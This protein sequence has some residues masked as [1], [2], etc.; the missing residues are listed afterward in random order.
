MFDPLGL[1]P[2]GAQSA[3][4]MKD[5][6]YTISDT[7]YDCNPH[8]PFLFLPTRLAI[9]Q[10]NPE[11]QPDPGI[12]IF[13]N[14]PS[15]PRPSD[16]QSNQVLANI[17]EAHQ[18]YDSQQTDP[19][20]ALTALVGFF[21]GKFSPGGD[22]D[23]KKNYAGDSSQQESA[24]VFGNFNFGAVLASFGA[25]YTFTQNAA[26]VAQLGICL[27]GGSCGMGAPLVVFPYGDQI[28][29]AT[30]IEQGFNYGTKVTSGCRP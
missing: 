16:I 2:C 13:D 7:V 18:F 17:N 19:N 29:D 8:F 25:T 14:C 10:P 21:I 27:T 6:T 1:V 9:Q 3:S 4:G 12:P 24:K 30:S 5:G 22:W 15:V 11:G 20:A 26:G 23:Y 28:D